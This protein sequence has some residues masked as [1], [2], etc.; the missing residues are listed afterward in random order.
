LI[1]PFARFGSTAVFRRDTIL[2]NR[3]CAPDSSRSTPQAQSLAISTST[4]FESFSFGTSPSPMLTANVW[5]LIRA[6]LI[7]LCE[8]EPER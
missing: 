6:R 2:L 1:T 7:T 8:A 4:T 5:C 3:L